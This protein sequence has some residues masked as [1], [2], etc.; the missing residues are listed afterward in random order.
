ME[1]TK[2]C[3][4]AFKH[5]KLSLWFQIYLSFFFY[6]FRYIYHFF[7]YGFRYIYHFGHGNLKYY[8]INEDFDEA[9]LPHYA[10]K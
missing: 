9:L 2:F 3:E 1:N 6:G 4:R 8:E 5:L 7:F 10:D